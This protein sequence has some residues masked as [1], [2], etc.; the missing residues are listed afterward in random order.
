[1]A[2]VKDVEQVADD[3]EKLVGELRSEIQ[4]GTDFARLT[5]IADE[6]SEHA[7]GAAETFS[8]VNDTLMSRIGELTGR[9]SSGQRSGNQTKTKASSS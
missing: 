7:D 6:I 1:M 5:Q 2:S 3:L 9:K 4:G 8:N